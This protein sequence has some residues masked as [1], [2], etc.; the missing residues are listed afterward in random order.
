MPDISPQPSLE[1][2]P[3]QP[4]AQTEAKKGISWKKII[5]T[6]VVIAAVLSIVC[7]LLWWFVFR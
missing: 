3:T 2:P 4:Q 6:I 7:V 5:V 1:N